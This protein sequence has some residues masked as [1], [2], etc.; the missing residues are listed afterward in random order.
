MTPR[1]PPPVRPGARIG[2][3]A[4]SGPVDADRLDA[5]LAAL[6]A[7][8]FE[9]V[10]ARNLRRRHDLFAGTDRERLAGF[11]ELASDPSLAAIFFARGGHGLLRVLPEIDWALLARH[12]HDL[13]SSLSAAAPARMANGTSVRWGR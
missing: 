6:L 11:H 3:A 4:L 10:A 12:P 7:L 2:V 5:G 1:L 9:V 13:A 8:G